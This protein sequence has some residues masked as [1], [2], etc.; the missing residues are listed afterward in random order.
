MRFLPLLLAGALLL[1][2]CRAYGPADPTTLPAPARPAVP[3]ATPVPSAPATSFDEDVLY[4][5]GRELVVPVAPA[6]SPRI[7]DS[8]TEGRDRGARQHNAIDIMAPRGT[9]V[10]A[11]DS[12]RVLRMST[13]TL[14]GITLYATDPGE[15]LVYYYAHLDAYHPSVTQGMRIARGDTLGFVGSTGNASADAPHLHF[16]VM[17]MPPDRRYCDGTPINPYP[18]LA[19]AARRT[20]GGAGGAQQAGTA[21]DPR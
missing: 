16:Q 12:G 5:E 13:S 9:P 19:G 7:R 21:R 4:L 18:V 11:A 10:L 6:V 1:P 15:R 17:R 2:A 20:A 3:V 14:G 8:F